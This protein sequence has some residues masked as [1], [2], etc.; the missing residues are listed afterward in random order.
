MCVW[1]GGGVSWRS[2]YDQN[3]NTICALPIEIK[4]TLFFS[5]FN[6]CLSLALQQE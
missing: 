4:W 2:R 6:L 5:S 1:G 3:E